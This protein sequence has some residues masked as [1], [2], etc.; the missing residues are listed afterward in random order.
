MGFT[1]GNLK[2]ADPS[3]LG[4]CPGCNNEYYYQNGAR[5]RNFYLGDNSGLLHTYDGVH[6]FA[7]SFSLW[8][9]SWNGLRI[10]LVKLV[11]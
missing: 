1:G 9:K 7:S 6:P 8:I 11:N 5:Q 2:V 3:N 4:S 10:T